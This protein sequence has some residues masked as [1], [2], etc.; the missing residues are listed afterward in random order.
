MRAAGVRDAG[1]PE[2][3]VTIAG[4]IFFVTDLQTARCIA[5]AG[6]LPFKVESGYD[7]NT[8][9][10]RGNDRFVTIDYSE[11]PPLVFVGYPAQFDELGLTNLKDVIRRRFAGWRRQGDRLQLPA[12]RGAAHGAFRRHREYR[13]REL[14]FDHR[15]RKRE[16]ASCSRRPR[17]R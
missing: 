13:L 17:S 1:K 6:E 8:A 3:P 15:C 16:R 11:T 2:M 10:L 12:L 5:G 7:V 9:D 4:R 14:R